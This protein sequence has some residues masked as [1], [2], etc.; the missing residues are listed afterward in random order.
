MVE[1]GT[2]ITW[3]AW[4]QRNKPNQDWNHAWGAAP[5]NLLLRFVLG[6]QPLAPGWSRVSIRPNPGTLKSADGKVPTPRGPV[7][8]RWQIAKRSNFHSPC[9]QARAR[10][11]SFQRART[12]R[13]CFW[14]ASPSLRIGA[15]KG[16]SLTKMS[17]ARPRL[18]QGSP[19]LLSLRTMSTHFHN[20]IGSHRARRRQNEF[21]KHRLG[22]LDS[23]DWRHW[24]E[25]T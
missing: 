7:L 17:Q 22:A 9:R 23:E 12:Q 15:L 14:V 19:P 24:R 2:T 16:G 11:C 5:A 8:V 21:L 4:D 6:V 18:K 1:S 10:R 25:A 13:A 3:E 20:A